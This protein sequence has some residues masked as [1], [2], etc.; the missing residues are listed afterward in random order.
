MGAGVGT[1]IAQNVWGDT[2]ADHA[3]DFYSG[4]GNY[5]DYFDIAGNYRTIK[6]HYLG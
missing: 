1:A 3:R 5:R 2:G 6:S 4:R